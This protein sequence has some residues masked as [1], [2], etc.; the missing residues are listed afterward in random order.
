MT[1]RIFR[2]IWLVALLV[3]LA[4]LVLIMGVIYDHYS[5]LQQEQLKTRT[6][7]VAQAAAHEGLT[8]FEGLEIEDC[9]IT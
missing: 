4:S 7:L 1:Q 6:L 9:R 3:F 8:Y 5:G 2:S